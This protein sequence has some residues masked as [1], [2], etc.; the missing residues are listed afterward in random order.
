[1][2]DI[3]PKSVAANYPEISR[4]G[5]DLQSLKDDVGDLATHLKQDGLDSLS[6]TTRKGVEEF[7]SFSHK[8]E[9]HIREKPVQSMVVAFATG[10]F[11]HLL[12]GRR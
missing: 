4:I 5:G 7:Q 9:K 2:Q 12:L 1:M 10:V 8:L 11:A 6:D 3:K